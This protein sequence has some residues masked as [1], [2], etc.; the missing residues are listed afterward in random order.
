MI[1]QVQNKSIQ[2]GLY[3][4]FVICLFIVLLEVNTKNRGKINDLVHIFFG[5]AG[6]SIF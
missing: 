4:F 3:Y 6:N 5:L 2:I 1:K